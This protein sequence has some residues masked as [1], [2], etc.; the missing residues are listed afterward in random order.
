MMKLTKKWFTLIEMLIVIVII[1]ILAAALIPQLTGIQ[2]RAR[3][4]GRKGDMNNIAAALQN[5]QLDY[6]QY[7]VGTGNTAGGGRG[8]LTGLTTTLED[9]IA[10]LPEESSTS[11][12]PY[13]YGVIVSRAWFAIA[14]VSEGGKANANWSGSSISSQPHQFASGSNQGWS[15]SSITDI[16]N[17]I[18]ACSRTDVAANNNCRGEAKDGE[19]RY[20]VAN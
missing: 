10:V 19:S 7:P 17:A 14:S 5:Y 2:G 11:I 13:Q 18:A 15:S 6:N 1:G 3:D 12:M 20:V 8:P 4:T 16:A 9:Y